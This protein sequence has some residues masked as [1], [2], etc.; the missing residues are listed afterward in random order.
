M[1]DTFN[2]CRRVC[3]GDLYSSGDCWRGYHNRAP[4]L[5]AERFI[6]NPFSDD[7]G[8]R[9]YRTGDLARYRPDGNFEFIGRV[10][11]QVKIRGF[12]VE[13]GE[14]EAA[15]RGL[16]EIRDVAVVAQDEGSEARQLVAYLVMD[17][18][19]RLVSGEQAGQSETSQAESAIH[20]SLKLPDYMI[21]SLF[22]VVPELPLTPN[23]KLDRKAL[24]S[25]AGTE[26]SNRSE[27]EAPRNELESQLADIWQ[28]VL[29][30][31]QI[32]IRDNFFELGGHSLLAA[33]LVAE[34]RDRLG[35]SLL[36]SDMFQ[37]PTVET[38]A[39]MISDQDWK[40]RWTSLV[41]LQPLGERPPLFCLH[42]WGGG[43]YGFLG[44]AKELSPD[45][46]VYGLQAVGLD[47]SVPKHT[48][49]EEMARHYV[50]EMRSLQPHGPY[51]LAG[52]SLGGWIAYA[53]AQELK[54]QGEKVAFMALLDTQASANV[55]WSIYL[56]IALPPLFRRSLYHIRYA[57][58][59]PAGERWQYLKLRLKWLQLHLPGGRRELSV[60]PVNID[61]PPDVDAGRII[62]Y[63][64]AL[65]VNY[66]PQPYTGDVFVFAGSDQKSFPHKKFW[67]KFVRGKVDFYRVAGDHDSLLSQQN[68][69]E[70]AV[71]FRRLLDE[72]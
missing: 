44:L 19:E 43:A 39:Q 47:G 20:A 70:F 45:R 1:R 62:D 55:G 59:R 22:V 37:S 61:M 63:F 54:T 14:V 23:G 21:P 50:S 27:Y 30:R 13:P 40:P 68:V 66:R 51:H 60:Q 33:K 53:V 58:Q 35:S 56:Q 24:L 17:C 72:V 6:A 18:N 25:L 11:H 48:T 15:L 38:L 41:P 8:S 7:Q 69:K 29:K 32:G 64:D 5:T 57:L 36:I 42:G 46:P 26:L 31:E 34:I 49:V 16:P 65:V 3:K 71:L 4:E 12:R 67:K 2:R 10:D 52:Q 28:D 9:L